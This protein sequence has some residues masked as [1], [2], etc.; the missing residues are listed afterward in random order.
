MPN[1][2][3]TTGVSVMF[4]LSSTDSTPPFEIKQ[5]QGTI[6]YNN[7]Q[8]SK[9]F[10][11]WSVEDI[12]TPQPNGATFTLKV[13]DAAWSASLNPTTIENWALTFIPRGDT[14]AQSPFGNSQN[15]ISGNGGDNTNND[16]IFTL[17]LGNQTIK[18]NGDWDW[19]LM[20]QIALPNDG[21]LKCFASDPEMEVDT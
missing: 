13:K 11:G 6:T 5:L 12:G 8:P 9:D 3:L 10:E 17:S 14:T 20:V 18:I 2:I 19:A 21:P 16:G 7:N 1:Q 4:T 15:T